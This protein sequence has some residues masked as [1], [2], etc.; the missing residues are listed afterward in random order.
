MSLFLPFNFNPAS[1]TPRTGAYTIPAGRYARVKVTDFS[2]DFTIDSVVAT[3]QLKFVGSSAMTSTGI[4]FTNTSQYILEGSLYIS[5]TSDPVFGIAIVSTFAG[6]GFSFG[7][8]KQTVEPGSETQQ[9]TLSPGDRIEITNNALNDTINWQLVARS[10][11]P[12]SNEFW[13]PP[14]TQLSGL[15]YVVEEYIIP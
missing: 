6:S 12:I 10:Y 1:T 2:D 7:Q 8:E 11:A 14:S 13:V 15:G 4:V 3:P 9:V 5:S